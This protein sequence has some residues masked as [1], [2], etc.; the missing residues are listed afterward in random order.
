M[1]NG[2]PTRVSQR[3]SGAVARRRTLSADRA[4]NRAARSSFGE[5]LAVGLGCDLPRSR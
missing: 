3:L 4:A 1:F 2:T 5:T